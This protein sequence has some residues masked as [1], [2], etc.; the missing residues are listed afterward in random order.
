MTG[1]ARKRFLWTG[2]V[3][4]LLGLTPG[5]SRP[6]YGGLAALDSFHIGRY[7]LANGEKTKALDAFNDALRLNPQFVQAYVA[8]GKL[9]AEMGQYESALVD[10]NFALR[11]QPTHAEAFAYRGFANLS[12]GKFP[13]AMPD[14]EMA[15]RI[16]PTYARVHFLRG[17]ALKMMG[18]ERAS[19]ASIAMA[20]RLDPTLEVSQVVTAAANGSINE[21]AIQI[22]GATASPQR[23]PITN[24]LMTTE[25]RPLTAADRRMQGRLVP[26]QKHPILADVQPPQASR[27]PDGK[28]LPQ[29]FGVEERD[30][31]SRAGL[32]GGMSSGVLR[33]RR[34]TTIIIEDKPLPSSGKIPDLTSPPL[35]KSADSA[36]GVPTESSPTKK[37]IESLQAE[38]VPSL[39]RT[40]LVAGGSAA[41]AEATAAVPDISDLIQIPPLSDLLK[42]E[43]QIVA[44]PPVNADEVA[45]TAPTI[46]VPI[47]LPTV[48]ASDAETQP[49]PELA[50]SEIFRRRQ[51]SGF[52][53]PS[54]AASDAENE[55]RMAEA[56]EVAR[57]SLTPGVS[58]IVG[59]D[60]PQP[61]AETS[62]P[63][64]PVLTPE[65]IAAAEAEYRRGL[66]LE[67]EGDVNGAV[68]AYRKSIEANPKDPQVY[69]RRGHL[70]I[71]NERSAEALAD[72][73]EA[74]KV[75]PDLS[76]GY[77][78]RA[79]V[80]YVTQQYKEACDDYTVAIRLDDQHAQAF[81]ERGHCLAMLGKLSEAKAD[82]QAA[83]AL[84]PSLAKYGPKY[85]ME[86]DPTLS[87][88]QPVAQPVMT[89]ATAF[90]GDD[91][92]EPANLQP[93]PSSDAAVAPPVPSIPAPAIPTA[94]IPTA[95]IP[96][97]A[98][99]T[100]AIPT[101]AIP[102]AAIP[103]AAIPT[104]AI[105]TAAIPTA[106]I[107][108][109][110]IPT[111]TI[112]IAAVPVTTIPAVTTPAAAVP[113]E[114]TAPP[115]VGT[116][117]D[118]LFAE[119]NSMPT[120][121]APAPKVTVNPAASKDTQFSAADAAFAS[122]EKASVIVSDDAGFQSP[123]VQPASTTA[124]VVAPTEL[125]MMPTIMPPE[126]D[127]SD[128]AMATDGEEASKSKANER[129]AAPPRDR[130]TLQGEMKRLGEEIAANP[131]DAGRYYERAKVARELGDTAAA[132]DDVGAALRLDPTH[133]DSLRLRATL[134]TDAGKLPE[135]LS[136][137]NEVVR[138]NPADAAALSERGYVRLASGQ[139]NEAIVDFT[140]ALK[141]S[142]NDVATLCRRGMA[143]ALLGERERSLADFGAAADVAPQDA[144]VLLCRAKAHAEFGNKREAIA[145]LSAAIRL[146]PNSAEAYFER[147][148]LYAEKGAYESAQADRR[149][150]VELDPSLAR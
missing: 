135:A 72:F 141:S 50:A 83:L 130:A 105:P 42:V 80:R 15:L 29:G 20:K 60:K 75:A 79:H 31:G 28:D 88:A 71:D 30:L 17:Q 120:V 100:A 94:A 33:G 32:G 131:G 37:P 85:A 97:A 140:E 122:D 104:A 136:D 144:E 45:T 119:T 98:I 113:V 46:S 54:K 126:M 108:T 117:F 62:A 148:R 41:P 69:C 132:L 91:S 137:L 124:P 112:P 56:V 4:A 27:L 74:I 127:M 52:V 128:A 11:L 44:L 48:T 36:S 59:D 109:A 9:Y 10:L 35:R 81:I 99:P 121:A 103:T 49:A 76:N 86:S 146:N 92:Q 63:A 12:L 107:P 150:A 78:G 40:S 18:E 101:A 110:A 67:A 61:S 26:Y 123:A 55:R 3:L 106:A 5:T 102:T 87:V 38:Q 57:K 145:D 53:L 77:Y 116:A 114:A 133:A 21:H 22:N 125:P 149:R 93:V 47:P 43:S 58:T 84:D 115:R 82:R 89:G 118:G 6:A 23:T 65:A 129:S 143:F 66:N 1:K 147:S 24:D 111:A 134:N 39:P 70:L 73:S 139:A 90:V 64:A 8:R 14:L 142:P 2:V 34:T 25:P 7:H 13:E 19:A 51:A 95:A 96:T 138:Q 68:A 16:D